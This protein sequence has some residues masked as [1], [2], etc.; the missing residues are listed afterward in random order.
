M[1]RH[2][3]TCLA[4]TLLTALP[5]LAATDQSGENDMAGLCQN[6]FI[7]ADKNADAHLSTEE[8]AAQRRA[9]FEQID[10]NDDGSIDRAEYVACIGE[11]E[12]T[13]KEA[14]ESMQQQSGRVA[15]WDK[16]GAADD[17]LTEEDFIALAEQA[18]QDSP[19]A[20]SKAFTYNDWLKN[21]ERFARS[22]IMR[23]NMQDSDNDG[24]LTKAEYETK[25]RDAQWS[26]KAVEARFESLDAN[27]DGRISPQEYAAAGTRTAQ[28][29]LLDTDSETQTSQSD[30]AQN[31]ASGDGEML[32]PVYVYYVHVL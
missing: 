5:A 15:S 14:A 6:A 13:A 11:A 19:A 2:A 30:T 22:A 1:T 16:V 20:A 4:T 23:F 28:P 25:A 17:S 8:I 29:G 31:T 32:V 10:A 26:P 12:K 21:E 18:W 27:D 3:T 9:Q 24:V 7:E